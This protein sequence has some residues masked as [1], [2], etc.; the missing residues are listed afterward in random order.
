M[1]VV[2]SRFDGAVDS[3]GSGLLRRRSWCFMFLTAH[4]LSDHRPMMVAHYKVITEVK[5]EKDAFGTKPRS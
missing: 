4:M 3:G 1:T 5:K 2:F